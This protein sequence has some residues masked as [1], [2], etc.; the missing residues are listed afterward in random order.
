MPPKR[1]FD[2]ARLQELALRAVQAVVQ[3]KPFLTNVKLSCSYQDTGGH[4]SSRTKV[5]FEWRTVR[6]GLEYN[7]VVAVARTRASSIFYGFAV[8]Q[9]AISLL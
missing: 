5:Y 1:S 6:Q 3:S 7:H 2:T 9:I 4:V 8:M